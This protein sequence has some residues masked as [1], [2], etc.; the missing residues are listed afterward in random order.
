MSKLFLHRLS[1]SLSTPDGVRR[2]RAFQQHRHRVFP[3]VFGSLSKPDILGDEQTI[4][5][6]CRSTL[7]L[8]SSPVGHC[9]IRLHPKTVVIPTTFWECITVQSHSKTDLGVLVP[10]M[11]A[12]ERNENTCRPLTI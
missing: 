5:K 7:H 12:L 1:S 6:V 11:G 10:A 8:H 4:R 3:P 9:S 2:E